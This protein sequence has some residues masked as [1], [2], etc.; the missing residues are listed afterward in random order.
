MRRTGIMF[1][2]L[3]IFWAFMIS[4]L[5]VSRAEDDMAVIREALLTLERG[6]EEQD[7]EKYISVFSNEGYIYIS[8]VTT[9]DD[10]SDDIHLLG[11]ENERRAAIRVFK[12]YENLD[13]DMTDPK[14]TIN[15]NSAEAK[16]DFTVVF[17]KFEKPNIPSIYY[18]G[19]T[20]V[21]SLQRITG[22]WKIVRWQ[23]YEMAVTDLEAG[24][25]AEQEDKGVEALLRDLGSDR[26]R[27]WTVAVSDLRRMRGKTM[28]TIIKAL[29]SKDKKVRLRSVSVL[30]GTRNES[31]VRELTKILADESEDMDIRIAVASMLG[32]SD[33]QTIDDALFREAK[34]SNP[35]LSSTASLALARRLR[36]RIDDLYWITAK[37]LQHE[38]EPV[39]EAAAESIGIMVSVSGADLMEQRFEDRNESEDVRMAAWGALTKLRSE[40]VL[41]LF[42]DVL[43]DKAETAQVRI[44][45]AS[46]LAKAQDHE[47]LET[48]IG[49]ATDEKEIF[50]LRKEAIAALGILNDPK[51]TKPLIGILNSSDADLRR[52]AVNSL[53]Q[54]G[55]RRA[56][57][58]LVLALMNRDENIYVRR[59]AGRGIVKIDQNI[60]FGPLV[61]IMNDEAENAPARRMAAEGLASL[62]DN[63]STT[64]FIEVLR[65]TQQ[66][67]WLRRIAADHLSAGDPTSPCIEALESVVDDE[68]KRISTIAR[69][70]LKR[71]DAKSSASS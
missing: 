39:R 23:Q 37:G 28:S 61:Q 6:Y 58:P 51:A 53:G 62:K 13:L 57:R 31:A 56:L 9:P 29:Y 15:G 16:N 41:G 47:S 49:L 70:A 24:M 18:A 17:V 19:G 45:A 5:G 44:H 36:K 65:D 38:D 55:D 34:G 12:T 63:R 27:I 7:L 21:F 66:P 4:F 52:E 69:D 67:W 46:A 71:I 43:R 35:R 10:P 59:L 64:Q 48:L 50:E 3:M 22:A 30:C 33:S 25:K 8:D 1:T 14:I 32:E 11:V 60:A 54:L 20:N 42:R 2:T 68:D 40:S 26:L